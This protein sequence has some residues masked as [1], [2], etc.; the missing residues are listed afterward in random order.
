MDTYNNNESGTDYENS[1]ITTD[2]TSVGK[3][4]GEG[5][6]NGFGFGSGFNDNGDMGALNP[7]VHEANGVV[8]CSYEG[9]FAVCGLEV[10]DLQEWWGAVT[11]VPHD[12][13]VNC[14]MCLAKQCA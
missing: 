10:F 6:G 7:W 8:H 11:A 12:S 1:F 3:H 4:C 9:R 5:E 2:E 13:D 14:M